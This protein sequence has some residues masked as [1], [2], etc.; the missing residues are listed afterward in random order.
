MRLRAALIA[1]LIALGFVANVQAGILWDYSPALYGVTTPNYS[2]RLGY[3]YFGEQI[4]FDADVEVGAMAVYS[5]LSASLVG[6]SV[7]INLWAD[8]SGS[9]GALLQSFTS[10]ISVIDTDGVG[11]STTVRKYAVFDTPLSL[12]GSTSYWI[13]MTGTTKDLAQGGLASVPPGGDAKMA[14]FTTSPTSYHM[15]GTGDMAMRLYEAAEIPGVPEPGTLGLLLAG[16]VG[17]AAFRGRRVRR[18]RAS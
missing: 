8:A 7:T 9:P 5:A 4:H 18:P 12:L 3:Q 13:G 10:E 17:M 6:D 16:L 11:S 15:S 2:N 1:A 14:G